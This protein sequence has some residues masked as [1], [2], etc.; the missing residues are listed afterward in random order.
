M[1]LPQRRGPRRALAALAGLA[2]ALLACELALR[3]HHA[4][5]GAYRLAEDALIARTQSAWTASADPELVYVHRPGWRKD[6][7]E[8]EAH[9]IL[10]P[11]DVPLRGPQGGL[12]LALVGDSVGAAIRLP[13]DE[14]VATQLERRLSEVTTVPVEVLNFC[15]NGYDTVQEARQL[16]S[17]V[18]AFEPRAVLLLFCLNDVMESSTPVRWFRD[19]REPASHLADFVASRL[20]GV[21]DPRN[22]RQLAPTAGPAAG[23]GDVWQRAYDREGAG[24][25]VVTTGLERIARWSRERGVP[26][27]VAIAPLLVPDDPTGAATAAYRAQVAQ[28][29]A[30]AGLTAVD[31]QGELKG[32]VETLRDREGDVYHFGAEGQHALADALFPRVRALLGL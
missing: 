8:I 23:G 22:E 9:G 31:L 14:R 2:F 6:D 1:M 30:A 16:E 29:V 13:Y 26:V 18:A 10:R 24:W 11:A 19:P 4:S 27:L 15:V 17:T 32:S 28:A 12:R 20:G 21:L 3:V 25:R 5:S 7:V